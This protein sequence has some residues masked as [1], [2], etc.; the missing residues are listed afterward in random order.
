MPRYKLAFDNGDS[1][2]CQQSLQLDSRI[3]A[4]VNGSGHYEPSTTNINLKQ[5]DTQF[6]SALAH[7]IRN[8]LTN[9][10]LSAKILDSAIK[11]ENLKVYLDIIMRSSIRIND[12]L[13]EFL[14]YQAHDVVTEAKHS[15]CQLLDEVIKMTED[16]IKLKN[17]TVRKNYAIHDFK[18]INRSKMKIALINI[19]VNAIDSMDPENGELKLTT[20]LI[21]GRYV[22]Q[23]EDN[24]C[25]ISRK[26]L[27]KIFD[28]YFT[29]K[30][31][32]L[33]L[34]LATT[35]SILQTNRVGLYVESKEGK[36]T[37]FTLSF[38]N[39]RVQRQIQPA[40][41]MESELSEF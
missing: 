15:I 33:G 14:K 34:G 9:I 40:V 25:G 2:A 39:D 27:K 4:T 8:P 16:R 18:L 13:K 29:T 7:E 20:K 10:N 24:G 23:I 17:I 31:D 21:N 36:G 1:Q 26:N 11:D 30:T 35:C 32:G 28:P 41:S 19:V 6:A 12:L 22:I 38:A 5:P 3:V 37:R